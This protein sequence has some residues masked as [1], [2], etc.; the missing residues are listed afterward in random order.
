MPS[1][2]LIIVNQHNEDSC[3]SHPKPKPFSLFFFF[4]PPF[5]NINETDTLGRS[6]PMVS[7]SRGRKPG[8]IT[9]YGS[10][11]VKN[12]LIGGG[13]AAGQPFTRASPPPLRPTVE[14][15]TI[16]PGLGGES[17]YKEHYGQYLE[18]PAKRAATHGP[19]MK[20]KASTRGLNVG[21]TRGT[22]HIPGYTGHL[23]ADAKSRGTDVRPDNKAEMLMYSLDQYSRDWVPGYKGHR[24]QAP[25]NQVLDLECNLSTTQGVTDRNVVKMKDKKIIV[26]NQSTVHRLDPKRGTM[27]FFEGGG[28]YVSDNGKSSAERYYC[29]VRPGEGAPRPY[30]PSKTTA[31]GYKFTR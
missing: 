22:M 17:H 1:L 26:D 5:Q 16:A 8:Y 20:L 11:T 25:K 19:E 28:L 29:T 30:I 9:S 7:E 4:P 15:R 6:L 13:A 3:S 2:P 23:P 12:P 31:S 21:T 14:P 18:D 27:S 24:A 10:M